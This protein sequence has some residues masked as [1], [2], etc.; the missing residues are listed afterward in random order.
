MKRMYVVQCLVLF[1][2]FTR[3]E[4]IITVL[5]SGYVGL[6]TGACLA[7]LNKN[8]DIRIIC[9]DI[10]ATKINLLQK[11][12]VPIYEPG[13]KELISEQVQRGSLSFSHDIPTAIKEA[14][15]IFIAVGTPTQKN[16]DVNLSYVESCLD[17]IAMHM[18]TPKTIVIKSTV[19]IGSCR[20]IH[21]FFASRHIQPD[22]YRVIFNPEFLR[23]GTAITDFL[24]PDRIVVGVTS[25]ADA[26]PLQELYSQL[27]MK[28]V[29]FI[30]TDL[31]TAEIIKYASNNFLALKLSFI[32]EI[33]NIC[34][35]TGA[36]IKQVSHAIGLDQ[37]IGPYFLK[38]GP[39][40]GGSCLPKD[41]K[42][43]ST[44]AKKLG[45]KLR[46]V[47]AAI[48]ANKHQKRIVFK[49]LKQLLEGNLSNKTVTILGVA[50]KA[51]TDDI[52]Y[53]PAIPLIKKL[54]QYGVQVKV[55]DP[56]AMDNMKLQFP[57]VAYCNSAEDALQESDA[58][59]LLTDWE[60]FK[61]LAIKLTHNRH[62]K[63]IVD[64]RHMLPET[65]TCQ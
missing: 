61:E 29:P 30:V 27:I 9:A 6:V 35:A 48:K 12:E 34:E 41:S 16:G 14:D 37:R 17:T 51:N 49:K 62:Q 47:N 64:P 55:Y 11:G 10:D 33:A 57:T 42:A 19:P 4:Q 3:T 1:S 65:G 20:K 32:N 26:Q 28:N 25:P 5:G 50:F 21:S 45:I 22:A 59:V 40:Y 24:N 7:K 58:I 18:S 43:L 31:E 23:E 63:I 46:T 54:L 38:T 2:F 53:S 56:A 44:I 36:N 13:L 52:R 39:G 15:T 8:K 60:E